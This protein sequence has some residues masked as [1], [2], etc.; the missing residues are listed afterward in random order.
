MT[1]RGKAVEVRLSV[2]ATGIDP[3]LI[4]D[5]P[6]DWAS[7]FYVL[8]PAPD[9][10]DATKVVAQWVDLSPYLTAAGG[11]GWGVYGTYIMG[12]L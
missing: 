4:D 9:P 7:K 3:K 2:G 6:D 1:L 5:I 11:G 10:D 8:T 12:T